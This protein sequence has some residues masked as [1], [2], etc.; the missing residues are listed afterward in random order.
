MF[1]FFEPDYRFPGLLAGN[2]LVTPEFQISSDTNV[3]RQSNF[4]FGGIYA[5]SRTDSTTGLTSGFSNGFSSFRYGSH[6]LAMD[7]SPWMGARTTGTDYWTNNANLLELIR[8]L[9]GIL[10]AGQMSP[11]MEDRIHSFVSNTA[12]IAYPASPADTDRRNRLRAI[13]YFIAVSPEHAIQR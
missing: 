9:S 3:I 5:T 8:T 1:N 2:G 12:N 7:F 11:A 4:L 6:D 13:L 10:M